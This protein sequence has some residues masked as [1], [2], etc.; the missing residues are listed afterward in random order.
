MVVE[1]V[2]DFSSIDLIH[3]NCY[4][5]VSLVFLEVIDS[6]IEQILNCELLETLHS[7]SLSRPRLPIGKYCYNTLVKGKIHDWPH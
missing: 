4:C 3:R 1:Q 5:E 6:P 2:I 7:E